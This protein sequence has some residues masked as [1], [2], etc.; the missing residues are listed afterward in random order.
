MT[1]SELAGGMYVHESGSPGSPAVIFLQGSAVSGRMWEG[2]MSRLRGYHCLAPDLPGFG[3]SNRMPWR[4]AAETA[5]LIA[6]LVESRVPSRRAHVVG[7][8][9]GGGIAHTLL[10]RRADL[11]DRVLI[12]SAGVLTWWAN[13]PFLAGVAALSPFV[14]TRPVIALLSRAVGGLGDADQADIRAASRRAFRRSFFEGFSIKMSRAETA[15]PCPTLLV[16]GGREKAIRRSNA[17]LAALMPHAIARYVPGL[18]HGWLGTKPDLHLAMVEAWLAGA[19]LPAG[20]E[21]ET[22][23][24][25]EA[26]VKRLL[27]RKERTALTRRRGSPFALES[28]L[29]PRGAAPRRSR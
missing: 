26:K 8:S 10:A 12:D 27:E 25:P 11:L 18:G 9:W 13:G 23:E 16:A 15:A 17:A 7:L 6:Q 20:L 5:D 21:V 24:W 28:G 4:S 14:H 22:I 3:R 29:H 19:A 1:G 2:H